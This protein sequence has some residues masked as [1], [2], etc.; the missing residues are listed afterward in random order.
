MYSIPLSTNGG[1]YFTASVNLEGRSLAM[2]FLWNERDAHWFADFE[3]ATGRNAGIRVVPL[4]PLLAGANRVLGAG[5]LVV[6]PLQSS[7]ASS[8]GFGNLGTEWGLY[9]V[10]E[11]DAGTL[12]KYG[13]I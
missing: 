4:S 7:G 9:Y 1:G 5:D 10:T 8:L 6:L 13:V 11:E 2:R 12:R 3:N